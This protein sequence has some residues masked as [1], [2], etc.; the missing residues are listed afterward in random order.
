MV[1]TYSQAYE[2]AM[3]DA[4][5]I[6]PANSP[7]V[8]TL[9]T[10]FSANLL[11]YMPLIPYADHL[12]HFQACCGYRKLSLLDQQFFGP[13]F[14]VGVN[15]WDEQL[16]AQLR[17]HPGII[18]TMHAGSYRLLNFLLARDGVP[19]ALLVSGKFKRDQEKDIARL[20][21][22]IGL[23][24]SA[25]PVLDA[26]KPTTPL[27]MMRLLDRG[28]SIVVYVDGDVGVPVKERDK[29][30]RFPFLAQH[31]HVRRGVARIALRQQVPIYPIF[32]FRES[33]TAINVYA[34]GAIAPADR[35]AQ[36]L[37][38]EQALS[39]IYHTFASL[40]LHYPMQWENWFTLHENIDTDK[41]HIVPSFPGQSGQH[42]ATPD[43]FGVFGQNNSY[44]VLGKRNYKVIPLRFAKK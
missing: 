30:L 36:Q 28:V 40:L 18:C 19:H 21:P 26:D 12:R 6:N 31:I 35:Q 25:V 32:N 22:R 14:P 20:Y 39:L 44:F 29:L 33:D 1:F 13:D 17:A 43:Y 37:F 34:P 42:V 5:Q 24:P 38:E 41:R 15:G 2:K 16:T 23:D 4:G 9:F 11:H 7:R 8:Q 27:T 10:F 3:A